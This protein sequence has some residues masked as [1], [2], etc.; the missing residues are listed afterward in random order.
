MTGVE[1]IRDYVRVS[2]TLSTGGQPT[3]EQLRSLAGEGFVA[4]VNLG[5]LDPSYCLADEAG[6]V[7][8][9][10]MEYHP[11]PVKFDDPHEEQF[12]EF[13]AV[14]DRLSGRRT[15]AHC[16]ANK[17]VSCFVALY[18]ESREGW[19][20]EQGDAFVQRVWEPDTVWSAFVAQI[21]RDRSLRAVRHT[22]RAGGG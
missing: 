15:F 21:R 16:A 11:I 1:G 3:A 5:L 13:A 20:A 7:A 6:L 17:R 4:V 22:S 2:G 18:M 10:A 14:M 12:L 19:S 9:L 8:A